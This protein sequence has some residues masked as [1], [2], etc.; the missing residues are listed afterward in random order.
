MPSLISI[1][2]KSPEGQFLISKEMKQRRKKTPYPCY[3]GLNSPVFNQDKQMQH[4]EHKYFL[5]KYSNVSVH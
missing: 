3:G 4:S 2:F 1:S 5:Q